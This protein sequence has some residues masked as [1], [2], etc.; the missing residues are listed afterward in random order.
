MS[1][2][3]A[4]AAALLVPLALL[5]ACTEDEPVPQMPDPTTVTPT[6]TDASSTAAPETAE[7]FIR[8]WAATE[9]D[10][11]RT[12]ETEAYRELS[13]NCVAC[14]ELA[15]LVEGYYAA[16]GYVKWAGWNIRSVRNYPAGGENAF[17]VKV[18]SPPT[19]YK[20]SGSGEVKSFPGGPATHIL[21]LEAAGD[22]WVV[23]EKAELQ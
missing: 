5:S 7:E 4:L 14:K 9:S 12:G 2:H 23:K 11:E 10:M 1:V 16:G 17:A 18:T 15:D 3:R 8:R 22:S 6:P 13:S 20:E 19:K 21:T